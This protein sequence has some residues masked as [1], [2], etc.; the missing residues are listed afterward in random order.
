MTHKALIAG[1]ALLMTGCAS[2]AGA[3][4][5]AVNDPFEDVNRAVFDFNEAVD[6]A[7]L[8]HLADGYRSVTNT[9]IRGG[10]RNFLIN[11]DQPVV[12]ANTLLQGKFAAALDTVSRFAVNTTVGIGGILDPATPLGVPRHREDFGQTLGLWGVAEGPFLILPL[13]GPSN[14]RDLA[15]A[16]VDRGLDPLTSARFEGDTGVRVTLG[17]VGAVSAR[18]RL[19]PQ[20]EMMREQAEPYTALRRN[21]TQARAAAIRDGQ[22]ADDPFANLPD[23][24]DFDFGDED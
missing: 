22:E 6:K 3:P 18:E 5:G 15:G 4:S 19:E 20:I 16:G 13:L 2:K 23:F 7:V 1:L 8:V 24:D 17:V 11:L 14:L 10:V 21:Y 9:P 12:F